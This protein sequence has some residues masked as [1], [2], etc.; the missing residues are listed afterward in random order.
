MAVT[1]REETRFA[2][3]VPKGYVI[4][5]HE[6]ELVC[7][8]LE[9]V[10]ARARPVDDPKQ[11]IERLMNQTGPAGDEARQTVTM[12]RDLAFVAMDYFS[13]QVAASATAGKRAKMWHVPGGDDGGS[14]Q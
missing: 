14:M 7:R 8:M 5:F 2:G 1:E 12:C 10:Y 6:A 9:C 3:R 11:A 4:K 13:E